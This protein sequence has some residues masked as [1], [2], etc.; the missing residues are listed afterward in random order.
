MIYL[1]SAATT[2]IDPEVLET[3]IEYLKN[4]YGNPSSKYYPQ[5]V[6]AQKAL[7][8]ARKQVAD[9]IHCDPQNVVFTSGASESNNFIIKG[10]GEKFQSKGNHIITSKVEHKSVLET[11][12]YM[13]T[14]GFEVTYLDVD[15]TGKIILED[16]DKAITDRTILVS[17]MWANNEI[18]T[19]NDIETIANT[20]RNKKVLFH[21]DATQAFGKIEINLDAVPIDF[22]SASAHKVYGPKGIGLAYV[23]SDELGIRYKLPPLIHGGSQENKLRAGTHA[24]HDIVG[25]GKACEIALSEMSDYIEVISQ[26]ENLLKIKLQEMQKN[27][28]FNGDQKKKIPGLLSINIPDINNEMLCKYLSSSIAVSTGSACSFSEQ[29]HV[30]KGIKNNPANVIRVTISKFS[31][32]KNIFQF[33][34]FLK[35]YKK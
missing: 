26:L 5:A 29:S 6:N 28:S 2:Q 23:G 7:Q 16:L 12:K 13:E 8:T 32:E 1:D 17:I 30:Q 15:S 34:S 18:G 25:F 10:V 33:I 24:M 11:C 35:K 21:T 4:E 9:F 14:K 22:M 3:M 20:C 31:S 19:I 27:I